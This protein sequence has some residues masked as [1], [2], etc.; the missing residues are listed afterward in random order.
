V[1]LCRAAPPS[2]I[3]VRFAGEVAGGNFIQTMQV[4]TMKADAEGPEHG[5]MKYRIT[6]RDGEQK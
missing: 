6:G 1:D 4:F 3:R 5:Q 2:S